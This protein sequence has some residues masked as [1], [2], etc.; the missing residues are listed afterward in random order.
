[1]TRAPDPLEEA[2][3]SLAVEAGID[4]DSRVVKPGSE[5]GMPAWCTFR[6]AARAIQNKQEAERAAA[7]IANLRP[8][9]DRYKDSLLTIVGSHEDNTLLQMKNCMSV[10]NVVSG[11][12]MAGNGEFDPFKD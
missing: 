9:D 8:Q 12:I 10:G 5:R 3:R 11:V 2:A 6:D 4:P 1:M 7:D